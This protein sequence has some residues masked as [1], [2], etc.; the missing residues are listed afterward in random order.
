MSSLAPDVRIDVVEDQEFTRML[1]VERLQAVGGTRARVRGFPSVEE[2][3]AAG[4][5]GDV[6]VLDLQLE[7]GGIEGDAAVVRLAGGGV[8]VL[9]LSGLHSTE[10]LERVKAAGARGF[11]GKD[12]AGI[13]DLVAAIADVIAGQ[14]HFDPRIG[15]QAVTR[16]TLTPRQQE[17]LRLE[18]LGLKA[19][20]IA[21]ALEPRL[22]VPGVRRH[23]EAVIEVYPE[24]TKQADR[25]RLA[26][27]L[28]LVTPWEVHGRPDGPPAP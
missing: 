12:S 7:G 3:L 15:K 22:T 6:V 13:N 14:D 17:V 25:V 26:V 20:Q 5:P 27:Q 23:I 18:A 24:C 8:P 28:G 19:A 4:D 21:R 11:V 9:V 16:K 1:T 2:L 10:T